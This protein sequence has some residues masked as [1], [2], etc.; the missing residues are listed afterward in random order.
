MT[1]NRGPS[2]PL[3]LFKSECAAQDSGQARWRGLHQQGSCAYIAVKINQ[4]RH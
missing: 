4:P 2:K 1:A 3:R